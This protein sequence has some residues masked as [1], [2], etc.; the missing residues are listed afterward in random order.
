MALGLAVQGA[1][2]QFLAGSTLSPNQHWRLGGRQ[3][4]EQFTQLANRSAVTEQLMLGF[5]D[6]HRLAAQ[7]RHAEGPANGDLHPR[8]IEGQ[9][10]KIEEPFADKIAHI[11]HT[12]LLRAEH[13]NPFGVAAADQVLDRIRVLQV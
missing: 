3:F 2:H 8:D 13:G 6:M 5:I 12:Q 1:R 9:G 4:T 7:A 11:L 10:V